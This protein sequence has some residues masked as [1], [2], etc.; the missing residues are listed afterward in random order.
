MK[1]VEVEDQVEAK[2]EA[3]LRVKDASLALALTSA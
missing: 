1:Q 3:E 2:V